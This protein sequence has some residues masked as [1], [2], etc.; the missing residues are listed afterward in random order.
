MLQSCPMADK[1]TF[2][3]Y[4]VLTRE[5]GSL[6]ELGRE[7]TAEVAPSLAIDGDLAEKAALPVVRRM[8]EFGFLAPVG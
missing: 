4:E 7:I 5:N 3:H 6:F 1:I 8:L 2:D